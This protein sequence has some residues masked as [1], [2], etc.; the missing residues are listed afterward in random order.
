MAEL[1]ERFWDDLLLYIEEGKVIP[2][3]GPE[4]LSVRDGELDVPLYRSLAA[5]LA[6]AIHVPFGDLPATFDLNDVV[7][8]HLRRGEER[9]D[10]YARLLQILRTVPQGHSPALQML[11]SITPLRLFVSM[12]FDS[13]LSAAIASARSGAEPR[14]IAYSTNAVHD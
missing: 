7:A 8:A 11:A 13:Q 6:A 2:V 3:I 14:V 5:K 9:D 1:S 4:L 10:L 12:T